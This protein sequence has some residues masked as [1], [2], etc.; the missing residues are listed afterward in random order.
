MMIAKAALELRGGDME[1]A[2]EYVRRHNL[3]VVMSDRARFPK[4]YAKL[5]A[6]GK[7]ES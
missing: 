5:D 3:A 2:E 4:Y 1:L 6:E 7:G